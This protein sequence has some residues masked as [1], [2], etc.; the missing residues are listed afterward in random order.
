M[1]AKLKNVDLEDQARLLKATVSLRDKKKKTKRRRPLPKSVKPVAHR[2]SNQQKRIIA[3]DY[4]R[5][6]DVHACVHRTRVRPG[7]LR[8]MLKNDG[9]FCAYVKELSVIV[10]ED[11][12]MDAQ[13][14]LLELSRL[15]RSNMKD[16]TTINAEGDVVINLS[17]ASRA[18]MAAVQSIE[19]EAYD[20]GR[21]ADK[22]VVKRT[23]FRLHPKTE[24][25]KLLGAHR[26]LWDGAT[27][28][29]LPPPALNIRFTE[30]EKTA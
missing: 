9:L 26:K 5:D 1:G 25:L 17:A 14:V 15:A 13:E 16:Y 30:E 24:A 27:G 7:T 12:V 18:Q 8:N 10:V 11:K 19:V 6:F 22:Q 29:A 28:T 20:E 23:K 4:V 3:A 2:M 21:G